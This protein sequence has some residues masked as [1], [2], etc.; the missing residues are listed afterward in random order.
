[1]STLEEITAAIEKLSAHDVARVRAWLAEFAE[2]RRDDEIELNEAGRPV[3]RLD[4]P[5]AGGAT[6]R[7]DSTPVNHHTTADFWERLPVP[8][9]RYSRWPIAMMP[10][11]GR[12]QG[13]P[14]C[15]S[16]L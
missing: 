8:P 6:G 7:A 16:S 2:Q 9:R 15:T 3:R 11:F 4:R 12:T 13:I 1:M 14:P 10:C 5:G